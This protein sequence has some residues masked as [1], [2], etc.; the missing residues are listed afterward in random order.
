MKSIYA[1]KWNV[2]IL[3]FA[4]LNLRTNSAR[5]NARLVTSL[6]IIIESHLTSEILGK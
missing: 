3:S 2:S 6:V 5:S 1:E 4:M